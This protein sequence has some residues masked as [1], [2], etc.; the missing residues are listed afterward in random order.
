MSPGGAKRFYLTTAIDYANGLPHI[1]HAFEKIGADAMARYHRLQGEHVHFLIGMDE[2]GQKV[3]QSA[4][5]ARASRR[6]S[7]W[8]TSAAH[9]EEAWKRLLHQQRRLHPHHASRATSARCRR[10]SGAST[11]A[12]D[13]YK[14]STAATTASAAKRSRRKTSW[15][16]AVEDG[17]GRRSVR[18]IRRA[19]S[20]WTEEE[21]WF[22]RLSAL[23][24]PAAEAAGRA[25]RVRPARH[26]RATRSGA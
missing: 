14:A 19:R 4:Q 18:C 1:G 8:T 24:G 22:F 7:G 16:T 2:H 3:L 9:F 13:L 25:S 26:P 11:A 5:S 6:S 20:Q 15:R 17:E 12:G 23:P 21:N 10:S